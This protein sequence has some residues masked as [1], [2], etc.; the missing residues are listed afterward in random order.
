M[1]AR[2]SRNVERRTDV[3]HESP[4]LRARV[5]KAPLTSCEIVRSVSWNVDALGVI[6]WRR[7]GKFAEVDGARGDFAKASQAAAER[8]PVFQQRSCLRETSLRG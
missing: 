7:A 6:T 4:Y 8:W 5:R 3:S 1:T 2:L